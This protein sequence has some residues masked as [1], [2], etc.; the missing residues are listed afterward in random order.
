MSL[1]RVLFRFLEVSA[2]NRECVTP[3]NERSPTCSS[4]DKVLYTMRNFRD[5]NWMHSAIGHAVAV[6]YYRPVTLTS[7]FAIL[8]PE[9]VFN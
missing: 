5:H 4:K 1:Y 8:K 3:E 9:L 6:L 7:N 2:F